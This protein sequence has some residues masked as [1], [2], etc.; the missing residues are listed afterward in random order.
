M[1]TKIKS[2][3]EFLTSR[4]ALFNNLLVW[5]IR[6]Q[7]VG[8]IIMVPSVILAFMMNFGIIPISWADALLWTIGIAMFP[9]FGSIACTLIHNGLKRAL[10]IR[11]TKGDKERADANRAH[12]ADI[13]ADEDSTN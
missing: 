6:L 5:R 13:Q 3:D 12:L 10:V 9:L 1:P 11:L 4:L 8:G 2:D 7:W